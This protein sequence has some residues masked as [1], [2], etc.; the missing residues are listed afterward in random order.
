MRI[1]GWESRLW[2]VIN[3]AKDSPYVLGSHD[4]FRLACGVLE[5]ITGV[6]RWSEFQGLYST[7]GEA[8]RLIAKHGRTFE[9]AFTWFFGIESKPPKFARRGD[10]V[11]IEAGGEKH[12]GV[13]LGAKA[14]F[15]APEGLLFVLT[16]SCLCCW[17][18]G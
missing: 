18:V 16:R 14:A 15:L 3:A 9:E 4:C 5:A 2:K 7:T 17:R 8:K 13:V 1:D 6:D 10:I 12:L 11:A